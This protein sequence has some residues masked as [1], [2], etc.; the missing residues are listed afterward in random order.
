MTKV[1]LALIDND[2]ALVA[3]LIFGIVLTALFVMKDPN[4]P[5]GM[6]IAALA[7]FVTGVSMSKGS[8]GPTGP[9]N[10]IPPVDVAKDAAKTT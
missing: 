6:G 1:I 9:A 10:V 7:G 4:N 5:V 2:K 8:L 3:I